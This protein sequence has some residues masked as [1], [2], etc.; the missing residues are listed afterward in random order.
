MPNPITSLFSKIKIWGSHPGT[1]SWPSLV[2]WLSKDFDYVREAGLVYDNSVVAAANSWFWRQL[3]YPRLIVEQ[4]S[5]NEWDEME[6]HPLP[7]AYENGPY[8]DQTVLLYGTLLSMFVAGNSYWLIARSG[9]RKP[10]GFYYV[11]HWSMS[12]KADR[13]NADGTQ[14]IT[15]YEYRPAGGVAENVAIEDVVHLRYGLNPGNPMYGISPLAAALR[16][17]CT[18]NEIATLSA[19]LLRNAG[20]T[21]L[22]MSPKEGKV[23]KSAFT[24]EAIAET[25]RKFR[26]QTTGERA[27]TPI[28][29]PAP[30]DVHNIGF[31]PDEIIPE[32]QRRVNVER[33]CVSMGIDPM[34]LGFKSENKTYSNY[35]EANEAAF[36]TAVVPMLKVLSIQLTRQVL[37][38]EYGAAGNVRVGWDLSEVPALQDDENELA[39]RTSLLFSS[40]V[41]TRAEA[42]RALKMDVDEKRDDVYMNELG[43]S[44]NPEQ[45]KAKAD[46]G[47]KTRRRRESYEIIGNQDI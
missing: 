31:K 4:Y 5:K 38:R 39:E 42:K 14:F 2:Q 32:I 13:D 27:G 23:D 41:I 3:L 19:A 6:G 7:L 28:F 17:V 37:R 43:A 9:A 45:A 30:Y 46:I 18:E 24:P 36:E 21:A 25:K 44:A 22:L 16:E 47:A 26:D 40:N 34:V 8:Y 15:H 33:I 11:P 12:P 1:G 10:A 20:L 29:M 35:Q